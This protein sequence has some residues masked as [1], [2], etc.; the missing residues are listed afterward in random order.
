M[1]RK[2]KLATERAETTE[3]R[4]NRDTFAFIFLCSLWPL[5]LNSRRRPNLINAG[6][7]SI[8]NSSLEGAVKM[9]LNKKDFESMLVREMQF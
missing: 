8:D 1:L 2:F 6:L 9:L 3:R 5:W 4:N 7:S